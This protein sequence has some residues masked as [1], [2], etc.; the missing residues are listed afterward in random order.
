[1]AQVRIVESYTTVIAHSLLGLFTATTFELFA[2]VGSPMFVGIPLGIFLVHK[3]GADL[4]RRISMTLNSLIA[5]YGFAVSLGTIFGL[6][7]LGHGAWAIVIGI[8]TLLLLRF[9]RETK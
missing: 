8:D 4:F 9:Y 1:V 2:I 5:G 3:L 6:I 7:V